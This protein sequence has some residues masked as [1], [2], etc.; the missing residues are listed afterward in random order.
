MSPVRELAVYILSNV[1]IVVG[2]VFAAGPSPAVV[3]QDADPMQVKQQAGKLAEQGLYEEA[4]AKLL[5]CFD[6]GAKVSPSFIGVRL[7]FLLVQIVELGEKYPPALDA[8]QERRDAAEMRATNN[9]GTQRYSYDLMDLVA[10]NQY[11]GED[12]ANLEIYEKLKSESP[13][14]PL[15]AMLLGRVAS[16]LVKAGREDE[17]REV[18][19]T[20]GRTMNSARMPSV[21]ERAWPRDPAIQ[22]DSGV[23]P[24]PTTPYHL[25]NAQYEQELAASRDE[26]TRLDV[27]KRRW[28]EVVLAAT[29]FDVLKDSPL[30][31]SVWHWQNGFL[32][33]GTWTVQTGGDLL[34]APDVLDKATVLVKGDCQADI[35]VSN[36]GIVHIYGDLSSTLTVSGQVE[37][38]IGGDITAE[39]VIE[40]DGIVRIFV[41]GNL[42]GRITNK[43]SST[44]WINGDVSGIVHAGDP[45]V[46]VHVIGDFVGQLL[47]FAKG[48]LA[49][50]DVR[51]EMSSALIEKTA[52]YSWTEFKASIGS[53]DIPAGIYPKGRTMGV[54]WVVHAQAP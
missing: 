40:G 48:S 1:M 52:R 25:G 28:D 29:H 3:E 49:S 19:R 22:L 32:T 20:S 17:V 31:G 18:A 23:T 51:G 26:A 44:L 33:T 16:Q 12:A 54:R 53:S 39:G 27:L 7:S 24:R 5:W 37:V 47:P 9:K 2:L 30:H 43:S 8:L 50:L 4:L 10:L 42:V 14:S 45:D 6:E 11:L 36:G 46:A 41:G 15:V 35:T 13:E 38:V 34:L 21:V